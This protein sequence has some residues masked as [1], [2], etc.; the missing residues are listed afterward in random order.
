M[1][2]FLRESGRYNNTGLREF[3]SFETRELILMSWHP[4]NL[5]RNARKD[6]TFEDGTVIP[7]GAIV[8]AP[9]V[10]LHRDPNFYTAPEKFDGLR[11]SRLREEGEKGVKHQMVSTDLNY[12]P[13]G[14]GKHAW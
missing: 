14:H 6:F 11:F 7:A 8:A 13:F 2:S 3:L 5:T 10:T 12:L 4:V 1:D 9:S